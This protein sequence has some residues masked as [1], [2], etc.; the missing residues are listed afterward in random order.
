MN[1]KR[2]D[3]KIMGSILPLLLCCLMTLASETLRPRNFAYVL[4]TQLNARPSNMRC[5]Q[6]SKT[7]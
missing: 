2:V 1:E 3:C 7:I 6:L 5:W 4:N